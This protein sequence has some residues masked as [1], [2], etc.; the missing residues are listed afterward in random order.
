[1]FFVGKEDPPGASLQLG[2]KYG[3]LDKRKEKSALLSNSLL[4]AQ[5][6]HHISF[7]LKPGPRV[8]V[9]LYHSQL[10]GILV[11]EFLEPHGEDSGLQVLFI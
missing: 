10:T 8:L 2:D 7:H 4:I 1:M 3:C 11:R 9:L 6:L 5:Q